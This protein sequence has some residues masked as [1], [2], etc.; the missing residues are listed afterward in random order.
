MVYPPMRCS[1]FV[2]MIGLQSYLVVLY[3]VWSCPRF[4]A[5]TGVPYSKH[6]QRTVS[7]KCRR[8]GVRPMVVKLFPIPNVWS[9][10]VTT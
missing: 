10:A 3:H 8:D 6:V 7:E 2:G 5:E 1:L 4:T 9:A